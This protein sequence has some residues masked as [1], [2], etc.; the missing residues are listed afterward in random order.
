MPKSAEIAET[1]D[2][3]END[4]PAE[5]GNIGPAVPGEL[6][7]AVGSRNSARTLKNKAI[8][9]SALRE[10][11]VSNG[12][13]GRA[14]RILD[15]MADLAEEMRTRETP[16]IQGEQ[17]RYMIRQTALSRELDGHLRLINK[18]LPDLRALAI[19]DTTDGNPFDQAARLWA[20]ALDS[21]PD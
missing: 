16:L 9:Q 2:T 4:K 8:N 10:R 20:A 3:T 7:P 21:E 6:M 5:N 17:A 19:Q 18:F 12:H 11:L 14:V 13:L 15:L 1:T